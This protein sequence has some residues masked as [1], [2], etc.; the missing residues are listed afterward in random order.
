MSLFRNAIASIQIGIEDFQSDD[1]RRYISAVRNIYAGILLLCKEKLREMSPHGSDEVLLKQNIAPIISGKNIVFT[2]T[3]KKTVDY[4]QIKNRLRNLGISV[5]WQQI[6]Q[7]QKIRNDIEHYHCVAPKS[8]VNEAI[9]DSCVVI[10]GL[11]VDVLQKRPIEVLGEKC[12]QVLLDTKEVFDQERRVCRESFLSVEWFAESC[13]RAAEYFECLECGSSLVKQG[14][15]SNKS[16]HD[17]TL[18]CSAC[19]A[20]PEFIE[21]LTDALQQVYASE[22]YGAALGENLNPLQDCPECT[23]ETYIVSEGICAACEF[24]MPEAECGVC[25]ESLSLEDYTFHENLCSYHAWQSS[26]DD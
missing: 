14:V 20:K 9:S 25:G 11:L 16:Q 22:R 18:S 7:I 17:I 24:V 1:S 8:Q 3:G 2:G 10:R 23:H 6:E 21:V 12:W 26:K 4:Q 15:S 5:E 13:S 19:N